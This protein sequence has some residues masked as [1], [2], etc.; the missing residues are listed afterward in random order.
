MFTLSKHPFDIAKIQHFSHFRNK[1]HQNS[2]PQ[3]NYLPKPLAY[4]A[5]KQYFCSIF[6]AIWS[7]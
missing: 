5:K 7:G 1:I 2:S 6:Y 3:A 4:L